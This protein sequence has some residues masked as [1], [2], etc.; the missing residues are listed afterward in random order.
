MEGDQVMRWTQEE[1]DQLLKDNPNISVDEA[2]SI[3]A[4]QVEGGQKKPRALYPVV[5][6]AHSVKSGRY[7][8]FVERRSLSYLKSIHPEFFKILYEPVMLR[9]PAGNYTPDWMVVDHDGSIYFYEV[10]GSGGFKAHLS[11]RDSRA[12]LNAAA[13]HYG[14]LGRFFILQENRNGSWDKKGVGVPD[15]RANRTTDS[16]GESRS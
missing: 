11:G 13:F 12:K 7:R 5:P 3:L 4:G 9:T 2:S 16:G 6:P 10:K 15:V 14:W 8:S 1:V